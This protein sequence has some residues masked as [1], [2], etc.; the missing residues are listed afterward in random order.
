VLG[1]S[2]S[3]LSREYKRNLNHKENY[4]PSEAE[5]IAK[6]RK[7]WAAE[8]GSKC[9]PYEENIYFRLCEGWTP[10]QIA[11]RLSMEEKIFTVSMKQSI[12]S[13]INCMLT[14]R[15]YYLESMR[16]A[17]IKKWVRRPQKER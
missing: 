8:I 1:R 10:E 16:L 11:G 12:N 13:S 4:L 14:G 9:K 2:G 3:A 5:Q 17:G 7:K 6:R 15:H